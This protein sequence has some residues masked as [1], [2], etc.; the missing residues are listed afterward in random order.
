MEETAKQ[1]ERTFTQ[2]EVDN[3]VGDRLKRERAK[4]ANYD[5]LNEKAGKYD[6]LLQSQ[7][8]ELQK[9]IEERDSLAAEIGNMKAAE[10]IRE[11]RENVSQE[12]GV[13]ANLLTATTEEECKAQA[14][15]LLNY[16]KPKSYPNVR[17]GGEIVNVGKKTTRQQ[18]ADWANEAFG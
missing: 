14:E 15:A 4:F 7:K 16:A 9:V 8:S 5:E 17:D 18:F 1:E 2:E 12:T 3:I 13:P 11:M 10:T 6:E